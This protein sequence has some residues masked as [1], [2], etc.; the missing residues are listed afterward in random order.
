MF[1]QIPEKDPEQ[2]LLPARKITIGELLP[3]IPSGLNQWSVS[4][5][6]A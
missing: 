2:N 5:W 4:F 6:I 3:G 1:I